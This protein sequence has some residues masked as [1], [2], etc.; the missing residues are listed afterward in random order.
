M[1]KQ[2]HSKTCIKN[3]NWKKIQRRKKRKM[4]EC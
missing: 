3:T 2:I 1:S 4:C